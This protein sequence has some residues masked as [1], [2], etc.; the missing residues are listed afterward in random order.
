[1]LAEHADQIIVSAST[2]DRS[3]FC[4]LVSEDYFVDEASVVVQS[5]CQGKVEGDLADASKGSEVG[6][7]FPHIFESGSEEVL[8]LYEYLRSDEL[9]EQF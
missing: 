2:G 5:S 1:M 6:E 8:V 3:Q 7:Q 9:V 4:G